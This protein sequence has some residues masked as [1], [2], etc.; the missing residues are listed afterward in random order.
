MQQ[1]VLFKIYIKGKLHIRDCKYRYRNRLMQYIFR[2]YKSTFYTI[3][4]LHFKYY[5]I[6]SNL[7]YNM[8]IDLFIFS[9]AKKAI[10]TA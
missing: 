3:I 6:N 2:R 9:K 8:L 4:L 10:R 7:Q 5:K 1:T